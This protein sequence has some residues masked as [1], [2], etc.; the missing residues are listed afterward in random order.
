[1]ALPEGEGVL[2]YRDRAL[3]KF[4]LYT[5]AR[6][7]TGCRLKVE[8]FIDDDEDPK[9]H[10]EEKGRGKAKR[11]LGINALAADALREYIEHAEL[12]SGPLFRPRLNPRSDKLAP[13]AMDV[14]TMYRLLQ[15]Y[16]EQVPQAMRE[17]DLG[18]GST[19]RRCLYSPHS[20]RATTAT[21]LLDAGED[22]REV[23]QLLGHKHVTVTQVYDKRRRGTR[24][25][26]SHR[27][28]L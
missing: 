2:A 18:D 17:H 12:S 3:L 15:G 5:G 22:I 10:I 16:L 26:A 28:S 11:A 13:R 23:Q 19:E 14:S 20:I 9:V 6:I 25:S 24:D 8:D 27:L 7:G 1:M 21:L 4:Y